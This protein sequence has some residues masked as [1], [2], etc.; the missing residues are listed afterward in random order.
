MCYAISLIKL[1]VL[2]GDLQR[3][4]SGLEACGL[5]I[6]EAASWTKDQEQGD[7]RR[8]LKNKNG[9]IIPGNWFSNH[10]ECRYFFLF[11][12]SSLKYVCV[13]CAAIKSS[14][15]TDLK[16]TEV[17]TYTHA[18]RTHTLSYN[19]CSK[20]INLSPELLQFTEDPQLEKTRPT[21]VMGHRTLQWSTSTSSNTFETVSFFPHTNLELS[22]GFNSTVRCNSFKAILFYSLLKYKVTFHIE[23]CHVQIRHSWQVFYWL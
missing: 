20:L 22:F 2:S 6:Q 18:W 1:R 10:F 12:L 17:H 7:N 21:L 15:R 19:D 5:Q 16:E 8:A 3:P 23:R 11:I 4:W 13:C 14:D 9:W